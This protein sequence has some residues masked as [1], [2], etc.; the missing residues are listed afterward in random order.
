MIS[1]NDIRVLVGLARAAGSG[2]DINQGSSGNVSVKTG[3]DLMLIKRSGC[4]M[5]DLNEKYGFSAVDLAAVKKAVAGG[6]L[7]SG[8]VR[9]SEICADGVPGGVPSV[10]T[11]FHAVLGRAVLHTHSVYANILSSCAEGQDLVEDMFPGAD[12]VGFFRPGPDICRS[13]NNIAR[14]GERQIIFAANH[15]L[16]VSCGVPEEI[17]FIFGDLEASVGNKLKLPLYPYEKAAPGKLSAYNERH[18]V[19][20]GQD[21][22][23]GHIL[24]LDQL[25]Y[26]NAGAIAFP[27]ETV[28]EILTA[29][30]YI[31]DIYAAYGL[32]PSYL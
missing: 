13:I 17:P 5:R 3:E 8:T 30:F 7:D 29:Y 27:D 18:M 24:T 23:L 26:I 10:E 2:P 19:K 9:D 31:S 21:F 4:R 16:I 20:Y 22:V 32:S 1:A 28:N 11:G 6:K 12:Y 14:P 25:L 15:G